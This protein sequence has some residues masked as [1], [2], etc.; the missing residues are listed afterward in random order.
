MRPAKALAA[1]ATVP[2]ST[3]TSKSNQ[4]I[5]WIPPPNPRSVRFSVPFFT[6]SKFCTPTYAHSSSPGVTSE[7]KS[8][9]L[10]NSQKKI[11]RIEA[12]VEKVMILINFCFSSRIS[13]TIYWFLLIFVFHFFLFDAGYIWLSFFCYSCSLGIFGGI[14]S[15]FH[16]GILCSAGWFSFF[17]FMWELCSTFLHN[18]WLINYLCPFLSLYGYYLALRL[19]LVPMNL[20]FFFFASIGHEYSSFDWLW[21]LRMVKEYYPKW[22]YVIV[23]RELEDI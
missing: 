1:A 9:V 15:L 21:M 11:E 6:R 12:N 4:N 3:R 7:F 5:T 20:F 22:K 17:C 8:G 14:F 23:W 16:Q 10:R 2:F 13:T 18:S 19:I